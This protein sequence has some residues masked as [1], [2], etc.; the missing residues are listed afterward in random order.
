[1]TDSISVKYCDPETCERCNDQP[2]IR[3]SPDGRGRQWWATN[4][5]APPIPLCGVCKQFV[6]EGHVDCS[7]DIS[8][9][10][11]NC[12]R[13]TYDQLGEHLRRIAGDNMD[14]A[15]RYRNVLQALLDRHNGDGDSLAITILSPADVTEIKAALNWRGD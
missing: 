12:D 11:E 1:M 7:C 5:I 9:N 6:Y 14:F 10:P 15:M 2:G 13:L 3:I 8:H 4:G